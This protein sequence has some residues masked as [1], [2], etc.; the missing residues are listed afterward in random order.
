MLTLN[1]NEILEIVNSVSVNDL[2]NGIEESFISYS[3]GAANIPP[4]GHLNLEQNNGGIHIK[5]GHINDNENYVI[6]IASGFYDNPKIGL[7]SSNGLMLAFKAKT[8]ELNAI[9]NDEGYLTDLRTA[10]AGAVC[11]KNFAPSIVKC[12][13]IL[14]T[15]IQARM[16]LEYLQHVTN[17][18]DVIVWG[19]TKNKIDAYIN[20]MSKLGFSVKGTKNSNDISEHCNLIVTTTPSEKP[21]LNSVKPGTLITAIGA[22]TYGKQ[23]LAAEVVKN[24]DIIICDSI[25]QCINHGE[26]HKSIKNKTIVKNNLKEL[27]NSAGKIKHKKN[28]II[29]CDLTGVAVQDIKITNLVLSNK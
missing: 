15:G 29:L 17:C 14:G 21:I 7:P 28:D 27:G 10:L 22:D 24:A 5:Y 1:K 26:I 11:A 19:R 2:I 16:Q 20:D 8:G 9:L 25:P 13:G 18:K 23:E 12:I 6:K 3:N 4:V